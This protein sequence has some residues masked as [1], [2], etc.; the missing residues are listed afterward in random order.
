VLGPWDGKHNGLEGGFCLVQAG[1][2]CRRPHPCKSSC[3]GR[4][5]C[6]DGHKK[7]SPAPEPP[8]AGGGEGQVERVSGGN[9]K[10]WFR[11]DE[12]DVTLK[13]S[14]HLYFKKENLAP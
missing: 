1:A 5:A 8:E 7:G 3:L 13:K 6:A 14:C 11:K 12:V 4:F 2:N 9:P 10:S